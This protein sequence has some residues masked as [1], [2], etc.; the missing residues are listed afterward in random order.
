MRFIKRIT[1]GILATGLLVLGLG[2]IQRAQA[3]STDTIA[4][5]VTAG[6]ISYGVHIS[7]P[8]PGGYAF[9]SINLGATTGS[10]VGISVQNS[11]TVSEYFSMSVSSTTNGG[12]TH[13]GAV[14]TAPGQDQFELFGFFTSSTTLTPPV[15]A[16]FT[17]ALLFTTLGNAGHNVYGQTNGAM[18]N[19]SSLGKTP[20]T[21]QLGS[22][23]SLWLQLT[24]PSDISDPANTAQ[25]MVVSIDGQGT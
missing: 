6:N 7:S 9:G 1:G 17:N 3:A 5:T 2:V 8:D 10:T 19:D 21:P 23:R 4:V 22:I 16:S 13:W 11:G 12:A 24:M 20:P 14:N 18:T 25:T 15:T